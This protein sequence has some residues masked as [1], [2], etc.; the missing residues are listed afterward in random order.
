M[1]YFID[2]AKGFKGK[3]DEKKYLIDSLFAFSY[4]WGLG[5]GLET[6]DKE[7]FDQ[8]VVRDQFKKIPTGYTVFDYYF[9]LKKEKVFKSWASK[10]TPF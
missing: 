7:K 3:D 5:G 6:K 4:A 8:M 1:E 2:P 10:V 9:D